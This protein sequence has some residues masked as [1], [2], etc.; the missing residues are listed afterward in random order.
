MPI[1]AD[2]ARLYLL[3]DR[4]AEDY[5]TAVWL[6]ADTLVFAPERLD[7]SE[8]GGDAAFG[9]EIW[10]DLNPKGKLKAWRN[11][12]NAACLFRRASTALP[13]LIET[14][15]QIIARAEPDKIAPQM[16]GPKLLSA[17]DTICGFEKLHAVQAFSPRILQDIAN[18]RGPALEHLKSEMK[19]TGAP[20][21]A[22]AN[23]CA[24]LV[25]TDRQ[26]DVLESAMKRLI[27]EGGL[28]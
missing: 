26:K 13:F 14:T 17:L 1:Q 3:R 24:S 20:E 7:L 27:A 2:L 9:R 18:G 5:E 25:G 4:L 23:L 21:P 15:E 10:V 22:A 16:V 12:H 11:T 6:D 19:R 28:P 8:V